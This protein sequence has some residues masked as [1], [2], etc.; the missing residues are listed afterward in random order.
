MEGKFAMLRNSIL[1]SLALLYV[2]MCLTVDV[3]VAQQSCGGSGCGKTFCVFVYLECQTSTQSVQFTPQSTVTGLCELEIDDEGGLPIG[4]IPMTTIHCYD[5]VC[6]LL[7]CTGY[8]GLA[9]SV[10]GGT[11]GTSVGNGPFYC[12]GGGG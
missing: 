10:T 12:S 3:C 6:T 2:S 4:F 7:D 11:C 8:P 1:R 5:A 9:Y